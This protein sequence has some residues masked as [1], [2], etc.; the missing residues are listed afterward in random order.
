M[1]NTAGH[2]GGTTKDRPW[3]RG[4]RK[5]V[6]RQTPELQRPRE[7]MLGFEHPFLGVPRGRS[8]PGGRGP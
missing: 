7:E 6:P 3:Q 8:S 2:I 1:T 4:W 5:G